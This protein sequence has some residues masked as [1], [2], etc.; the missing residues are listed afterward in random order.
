MKG[1]KIWKFW[2]TLLVA[3]SMTIVMLPLAGVKTQ[4][5]EIGAMSVY[6]ADLFDPMDGDVVV[7][8]TISP[9]STGSADVCGSGSVR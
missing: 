6:S 1:K 2:L 3:F 4:A 5:A 8:P 7:L 9:L